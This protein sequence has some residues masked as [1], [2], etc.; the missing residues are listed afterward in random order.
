VRGFII[1]LAV[2][3]L[4][5]IVTSWLV[6][7]IHFPATQLQEPAQDILTILG[8]ALVFGVVNGLIGP[9][10]RL[11]ALPIRMATLG[12]FSIV[13]NA[14][15]LL[16]VAW[17]TWKLGIVF[18]VGTFMPTLLSMDT[19]IGAVLGSIVIGLVSSVASH[20]VKD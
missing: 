13:I 11:L 5:F 4:A 1:R 12:L 3:G 18:K 7:Q 15:L 16:L 14:G 10:V 17:I 8:V 9:I 2:T 6:P 20:F 19:L